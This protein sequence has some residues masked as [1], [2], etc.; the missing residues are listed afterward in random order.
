MSK[1]RYSPIID[2]INR[3]LKKHPGIPLYFLG[4]NYNMG[5]EWMLSGITPVGVSSALQALNRRG[6][7]TTHLDRLFAKQQADQ[8]RR[9]RRNERLVESARKKLTPAEQAACNL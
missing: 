7:K 1:T 3:L 8:N 5:P 2:G 6:V 9:A 4:V